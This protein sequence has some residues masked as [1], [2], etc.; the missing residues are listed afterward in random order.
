MNLRSFFSALNGIVRLNGNFYVVNNGV[1]RRIDLADGQMATMDG[2]IR[3]LPRSDTVPAA[4]LP[5]RQ[6][7]RIRPRRLASR[8]ARRHAQPV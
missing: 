4:T 6:T 8:M 3:E 1:A 5:R 7:K 2:I